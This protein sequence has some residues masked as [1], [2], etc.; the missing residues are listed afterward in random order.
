MRTLPT[1]KHAGQGLMGEDSWLLSSK[2]PLVC[3]TK[4]AF[5]GTVYASISSRLGVYLRKMRSSRVCSV[6]SS[7]MSPVALSSSG[8]ISTCQMALCARSG[9]S[10]ITSIDGIAMSLQMSTT[11]VITQALPPMIVGGQ[12]IPLQEYRLLSTGIDPCLVWSQ[13][14][15]KKMQILSESS[16]KIDE[17]DK[18]ISWFRPRSRKNE[19]SDISPGQKCVIHM[20]CQIREFHAHGMER[21]EV[22]KRYCGWQKEATLLKQTVK[23]KTFNHTAGALQ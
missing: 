5:C 19:I 15:I 11:I 12:E 10:S 16:L 8:G 4:A 9:S 3:A 13:R 20:K 1:P 7:S 18:S 21:G 23:D 14:R 22:L 6:I 17:I 2:S